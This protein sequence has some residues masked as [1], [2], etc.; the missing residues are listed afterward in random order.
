MYIQPNTIVKVLN[1]VPL[2]E[3]Y[4]NTIYFDSVSAQQSYFNSMV[5]YTFPKCSYQRKDRDYVAVEMNAENLYNC[6]YIMFQNTSFGSKWFFGFITG[7]EYANNNMSYIYY[8]IDV[9]QTWFFEMEL[10]QCFVEREHSLT[11]EIDEN[12]NYEGLEIGEYITK[13]TEH[14][15][16]FEDMSVVIYSPY[17]IEGNQV[18]EEVGVGGYPVYPNVIQS[19]PLIGGYYTVFNCSTLRNPETNLHLGEWIKKYG[20]VD[21]II[22]SF[23]CPTILTENIP[24]IISLQGTI[25]NNVFTDTKTITRDTSIKRLDGRSPKNKKTLQLP[26]L[27]FHG[28]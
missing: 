4:E 28:M 10:R 6:N 26:L 24:A 15:N 19:V 25:D 1:G 2:D 5:K 27:S 13:S 14:Y 11:D 21:T 20:G 12:I 22:S 8:K 16:D 9:M 7:I 3:G 17:D 23:M 18:G